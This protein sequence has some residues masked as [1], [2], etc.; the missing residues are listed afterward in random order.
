MKTEIINK[1]VNVLPSLRYHK[2][3][4]IACRADDSKPVLRHINTKDYVTRSTY[5]EGEMIAFLQEDKDKNL[6]FKYIVIT[7]FLTDLISGSGL[8]G[9]V[10]DDAISQDYHYKVNAQ[11]LEFTMIMGGANLN[12]YNNDQDVARKLQ[13]LDIPASNVFILPYEKESEFYVL[14]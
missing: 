9:L 6:S 12:W 8:V 1:V 4:I 5:G 13:E 2:R 11:V 10:V 3:A 14:P 7:K